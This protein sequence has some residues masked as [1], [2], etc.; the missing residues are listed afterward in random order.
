MWFTGEVRRMTEGTAL[1]EVTRKF[2]E[3]EQDN[4]QKMLRVNLLE[5]E[6]SR[7]YEPLKKK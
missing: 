7:N 1:A 5:T 3:I 6:L 4:V 2:R